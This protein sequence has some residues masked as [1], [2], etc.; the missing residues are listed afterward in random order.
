M[1][2]TDT[3]KMKISLHDINNPILSEVLEREFDCSGSVIRDGVRTLRRDGVPVGACADGYFIAEN[4]GEIEDTIEDLRKR[5]RSLAITANQL[6]HAFE[7]V[8]KDDLFYQG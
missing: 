3:L 6:A 5:M 7:V 2:N 4:F 1:I 8:L